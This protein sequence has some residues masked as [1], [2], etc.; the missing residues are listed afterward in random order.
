MGVYQ[1]P[2]L[3]DSVSVNETVYGYPVISGTERYKGVYVR[4]RIIYRIDIIKAVTKFFCQETLNKYRDLVF[5]LVSGWEVNKVNVS[6][7]LTELY[8]ADEVFRRSLAEIYHF[9]ERMSE[10]SIYEVFIQEYRKEYDR[11]VSMFIRYKDVWDYKYLFEDKGSIY[12]AGRDAYNA[13][14]IPEG[15]CGEVLSIGKVW[16]GGIERVKYEI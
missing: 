3:N 9:D 5:V 1:L 7:Y 15:F 16:S 11:I 13:L 4:N 10:L 8:K 14:K 12:L 2:Y 6:T